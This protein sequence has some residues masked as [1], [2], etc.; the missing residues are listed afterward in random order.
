MLKDRM[1]ELGQKVREET[2]PTLE[3]IG[4][5]AGPILEKMKERAVP[6][7]E[8]AMDDAVPAFERMKERTAPGIEKMKEDAAPLIERA[9]VEAARA[10]RS[11]DRYKAPE[12][13]VESSLGGLI[14]AEEILKKI[15]RDVEKVYVNPEANKAYYI[16]DNRVESVPLWK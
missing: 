13:V 9:K 5:E 14:T 11:L 10:K 6:A 12:I 7:I 1:K 4:E 8:K 16:R 15:P 3:K 2:V